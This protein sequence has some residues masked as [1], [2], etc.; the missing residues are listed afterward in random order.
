MAP[1]AASLYHTLPQELCL[2]RHPGPRCS[3]TGAHRA[4][5]SASLWASH[6]R[7]AICPTRPKSPATPPRVSGPAKAWKRLAGPEPR[8]PLSQAEDPRGLEHAVLV[9]LVVL[10]VLAVA[11]VVVVVAAGV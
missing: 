3:R 6:D 8:T 5:P 11:V 10:V 2:N 9:V 1:A 4:S 7:D